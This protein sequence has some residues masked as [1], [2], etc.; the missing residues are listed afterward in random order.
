MNA[1]ENIILTCFHVALE[2]CLFQLY[3]N[4]SQSHCA[5][6]D[7]PN[8]PKNTPNIVLPTGKLV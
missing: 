2:I 5:V 4:I 3:L 7:T 1:I 8:T 6:W